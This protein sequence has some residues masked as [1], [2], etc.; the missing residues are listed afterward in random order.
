MIN[1]IEYY[2]ERA[3]VERERAAESDRADVAEVH[4]ELARLYEAMVEQPALRS[5]KLT[6]WPRNS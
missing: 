3:R 5:R 2:R 4:S 1:D 6:L